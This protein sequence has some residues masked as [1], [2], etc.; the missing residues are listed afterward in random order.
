MPKHGKGEAGKAGKALEVSK[1]MPIKIT[2]GLLGGLV[3]AVVIAVL[4][5]TK[6]E[7]RIRD[8]EADMK[9][10]TEHHEEEMRSMHDRVTEARNDPFTGR[11][12]G[13]YIR[14][15]KESNRNNP[16]ISIPDWDR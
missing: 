15:L 12:F 8:L 11:D 5:W 16:Q 7:D 4:W 1:Q 10:L 2:L 13:S 9:H 3:V 6:F 14:L